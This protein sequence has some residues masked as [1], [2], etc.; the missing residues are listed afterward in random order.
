MTLYE[1]EASLETFA[2]DFQQSNNYQGYTKAVA[3]LIN[4]FYSSQ[5]KKTSEE[6]VCE[7][8][9]FITARRAAA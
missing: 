1:F 3:Q 7:M 8:L 9:D 6:L 4:D 5:I 2:L